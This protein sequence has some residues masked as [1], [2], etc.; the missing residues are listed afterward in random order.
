MNCSQRGLDVDR[1]QMSNRCYDAF[2]ST[3]QASVVWST[4]LGR[5]GYQHRL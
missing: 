4:H 2:T 5:R 1:R 3:M